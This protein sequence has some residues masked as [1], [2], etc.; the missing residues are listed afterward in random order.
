MKQTSEQRIAALEAAVAAHR[1][2]IDLLYV[3]LRM[4]TQLSERGN[5]V[6]DLR[7]LIE[8]VRATAVAPADLAVLDALMNDI[9]IRPCP[10]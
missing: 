3:M 10:V 2:E 9:A 1:V 7:S 5:G 8:R 4:A 6:S